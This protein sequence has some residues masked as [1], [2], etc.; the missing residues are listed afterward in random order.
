MNTTYQLPHTHNC[1]KNPKNYNPFL[2]RNGEA[3]SAYLRFRLGAAKLLTLDAYH[4]WKY[5]AFWSKV[6]I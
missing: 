3:N 6:K 5:V 1:D 2:N 4:R